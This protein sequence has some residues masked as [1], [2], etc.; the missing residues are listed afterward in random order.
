MRFGMIVNPTAGPTNVSRKAQTLRAVQEILGDCEIRGLDT[1][2]REEFMHCAAEL[3]REVEVLIV[4]GGDGSFSDAVNALDGS[5]TFSYLPLGS[6]CALQYALDLPPQLTRVAKRIKE[7]C[8]HF[9]DLI[10]CD[11]TRKAFMAS[12]GLEADILHRREALRE[13]GINGPPAYAMAAFGS[14]FTELER[15]DMTISLDSETL[16]VPNAVTAI[17][18]KIPYYGYKMRVVPNAV[19][20]DG[21]LHLL[22][23]N[24]GWAEIVGGMANAFLY[25]NKLGLYRKAR[26]IR[27]TMERQRYAQVDGGIYRK[28]TDF[29][30]RVLPRALRMWC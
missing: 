27:I 18:T 2:S 20:D 19:F 14:F 12:I 8:L 16:V 3:A 7:G 25:E 4:A 17:V 10:L 21:H 15:T 26:E 13:S 22:A 24:S 23:I 11:E 5:T 9:Y 29:R 6:G 30:F 1:R 28:G